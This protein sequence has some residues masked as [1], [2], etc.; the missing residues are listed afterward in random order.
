[1]DNDSKEAIIAL[2]KSCPN[3]TIC[4]LQ[5]RSDESINGD[6][7]I[8]TVVRHCPLIEVLPIAKWTLTDAAVDSLATIHTLKVIKFSSDS[9]YT[10]ESLQHAIHANPMLEELDLCGKTSLDAASVSSI[11]RN[12]GNLRKVYIPYYRYTSYIFD[13]QALWSVFHGCPLL[14]VVKLSCIITNATLRTLFQYCRCLSKLNIHFS[15]PPVDTLPID[16]EPIFYEIYP[17]LTYLCLCYTLGGIT[18]IVFRDIFTYCTSLRTVDIAACHLLTDDLLVTLMQFCCKLEVLR[19]YSCYYITVGG[20]LEA[21]SRC[22]AI[23]ELCVS[24]LPFDDDAI[25]QLSLSCPNLKE[26][27]LFSCTG[28]ITEVGVLA[29]ADT[30]TQLQ[31]LT[32]SSQVHK[33]SLTPAL[34]LLCDNSANRRLH[35]S[36]DT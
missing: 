19:L 13:S 16:N 29:V 17:S 21:L 5:C 23:R 12:C 34:K 35:V 7:V 3:L 26:F 31:A 1:M 24:C 20:L 18:D 36:I 33:I 15:E 28:Y 10:S 9:T 22:P 30:C 32:I 6:E 27:G 25:V 11:G 2:C 8:Q 14:E 4:D